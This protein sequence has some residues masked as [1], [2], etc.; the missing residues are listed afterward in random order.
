MP[1]RTPEETVAELLGEAI[2][3][4][5]KV[6]S[7]E[8]MQNLPEHRVKQINELKEKLEDCLNLAQRMG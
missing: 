3:G 1:I 5:Q 7:T 6:Y 2:G 8:N 4:Y